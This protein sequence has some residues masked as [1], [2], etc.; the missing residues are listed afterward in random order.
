MV[1]SETFGVVS[2]TPSPSAN[3]LLETWIYKVH[4]GQVARFFLIVLNCELSVYVR[5]FSL[6]FWRWNYSVEDSWLMVCK[7]SVRSHGDL[8]MD[9]VMSLITEPVAWKSRRVDFWNLLW[10]DFKGHKWLDIGIYEPSFCADNRFQPF[11]EIF[12]FPLRLLWRWMSSLSPWTCST[13]QQR[14]WST[15]WQFQLA[16]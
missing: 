7:V 4:R 8:T 9:G 3:D 10:N 13:P 5:N 12:P 1:Y 15:F 6:S 11:G 16:L 14:S 2:C